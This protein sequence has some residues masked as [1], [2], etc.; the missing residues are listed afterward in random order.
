[1]PREWTRWPSAKLG[2]AEAL[3]VQREGGTI[4]EERAG[5][6]WRATPGAR[7]LRDY[8]LAEH[9]G[10][11]RTFAECLVADA[12]D[13]S[14]GCDAFDETRLTRFVRRYGVLHYRHG[15]AE[16]FASVAFAC[17]L[18]EL[19]TV[20]SD[21]ADYSTP[22]RRA[23][24]AQ[25]ALGAGVLMAGGRND[26]L[27]NAIARA[28]HWCTWTQQRMRRC[29]GCGNWMALTRSTRRFCNSTCRNPREED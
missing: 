18:R 26:D 21:N 22:S 11:W 28:A 16:W 2:R 5:F 4:L 27:A 19:A 8:P 3:L 24:E 12:T 17:R 20:W 1:M 14:D 13:A 15:P 7:A 23:L 29:A 25:P 6:A 10:A 9:E